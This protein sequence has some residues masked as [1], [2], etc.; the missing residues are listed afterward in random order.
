VRCGRERG[1][2]E[3][4]AGSDP[5]RHYQSA[6]QQE[7]TDLPKFRQFGEE[8]A[9]ADGWALYAASLAS[10]GLYRDDE[11]KGAHF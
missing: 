2:R 3:F 10:T 4:S 7:R 8:P 6:L 11:A 1:D 9:F 5:G